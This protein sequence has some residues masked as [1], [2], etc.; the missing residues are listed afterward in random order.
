[1]PKLKNSKLNFWT[2][3]TAN[4]VIFWC[5]RLRWAARNIFENRIAIPTQTFTRVRVLHYYTSG[6]RPWVR[7][8]A[9]RR[10]DHR[11]LVVYY[12]RIPMPWLLLLLLFCHSSSAVRKDVKVGDPTDLSFSRESLFAKLFSLRFFLANFEL[13]HLWLDPSTHFQQYCLV[14][15]VVALKP[16]LDGISMPLQIELRSYTTNSWHKKTISEVTQDLGEV[17]LRHPDWK[18]KIENCYIIVV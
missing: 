5:L 12:T 8:A 15:Y 9:F 2:L 4:A 13:L 16:P 11:W 6:R 7:N 10:H 1:M 18:L 14:L 17:L 3:E